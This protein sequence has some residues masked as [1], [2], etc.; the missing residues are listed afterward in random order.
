M[1]TIRHARILGQ[2]RETL[3]ADL[4]SR[5]DRGASVRQ[6]ADESGCAYGTVHRLLK[7]AGVKF[8]PRGASPKAADAQRN[9]EPILSRLVL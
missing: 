6:L 8:R 2:A 9:V 5:Y 1:R 3:A 7:E 4:R